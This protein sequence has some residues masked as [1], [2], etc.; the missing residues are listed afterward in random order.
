MKYDGAVVWDGQS[1]CVSDAR[2]LHAADAA[3]AAADA[4]DAVLVPVL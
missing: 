3:A 1:V 4:A 2:A